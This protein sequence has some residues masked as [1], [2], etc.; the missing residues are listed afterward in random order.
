[1]T[2]ALHTPVKEGKPWFSFLF[3]VWLCAWLPA[4]WGVDLGNSPAWRAML[5]FPKHANQSL[6]DDPAFFFSPHGQTNPTAELTATVEA[7]SQRPAALGDDSP[8]CRFLGRYRW[9][10]RHAPT[11]AKNFVAQDCPAWEKLITR[12]KP[13]SVSL[14]FPDGYL[15]SPA[16]MFGHTLLRIDQADPQPL[17]S[18]AVNYAA[19]TNEENGIAYAFN[20][21]SGR[22][23]GYY[24]L[25]PYP[26]KLQEYQF[27]EQRE[28][29]EYQIKLS[30]SESE[31]ML[32]HIWELQGIYANYYFLDRNCSY[33]LLALIEVA[34]PDL[35]L[36]NG[37]GPSVIPI[38]T[39]RRLENAS[40][41]GKSNLR[42]SQA[43][44]INQ[45]LKLL[46]DAEIEIVQS[47]GNPNINAEGID[48]PADT[49]R[50]ALLLNT[51]TDYLQWERSRQSMSLEQYRLRFLYLLSQ[52]SQIKNV[53]SSVNKTDATDSS[54]PTQGHGTK[55]FSAS[56]IQQGSTHAVGL[57]YRPA[58]HDMRDRENGYRPGAG[59]SFLEVHT[60]W[61]GHQKKLEVDT[62]D[63][64]KI[65]SLAARNA[66]LKP[67]SWRV[68]VGAKR[69]DPLDMKSPLQ[70]FASAGA[71]PTYRLNQGRWLIFTTAEAQLSKDRV[72]NKTFTDVGWRLG[73][74]WR[75]NERV[76]LTFTAHDWLNTTPYTKADRLTQLDFAYY[77]G[78]DQSIQMQRKASL[79]KSEKSPIH[80][81]TW[82]WFY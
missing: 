46:S 54:D 37:W 6:I 13:H 4:A 51:A 28:I 56:A 48:L 35:D 52:R 18:F 21:L 80:S 58:F 57:S 34:R 14:V 76:C 25:M 74:Q 53:K 39:I 69:A 72:D 36:L 81:L 1:M 49:E 70:P 9:L 23:K 73:T 10:Q 71:G 78:K 31:A 40:L 19:Q 63:L 33:Q 61:D 66:L 15:N 26:E 3:F 2:E 45:K 77:L 32:E 59:I 50:R 75:P 24:S 65:E 20:G 30:P 62:F 12:V 55:R 44:Q 11:I 27:G 8:Q 68:N 67:Y 60:R 41:V 38:D 43:T 42:P 47:L 16:S 29:W 79:G 22:Y 64:L 82:N 5:H 7:F 17:R